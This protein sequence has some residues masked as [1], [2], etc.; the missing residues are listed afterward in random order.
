MGDEVTVKNKDTSTQFSNVE[1]S[2]DGV[3]D[4]TSDDTTDQYSISGN[5]DGNFGLDVVQ[6]DDAGSVAFSNAAVKMLKGATMSFSVDAVN[7]DGSALAVNVD[8][9]GDGST[10][11][12][13]TLTDS[14][15]TAATDSITSDVLPADQ[16]DA[17]P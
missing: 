16:V 14:A 9:N 15:S 11:Q 1:I 10:D 7:Q 4:V 2:A 6:T 5:I 3:A 17:N 8:K 12:Q 13:V